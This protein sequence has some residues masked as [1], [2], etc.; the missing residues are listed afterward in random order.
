MGFLKGPERPQAPP[1]TPI[2]ADAS[3][4][5]AG[6]RANKGFSSLLGGAFAGLT[7]KATTIKNRL[8]GGGQ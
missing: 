4:L 2:Y 5:G 1:P 6:L 7:Q 3:V 8:L